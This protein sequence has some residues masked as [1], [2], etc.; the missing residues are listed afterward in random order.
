MVN[1]FFPIL[2]P[3]LFLFFLELFGCQILP[4]TIRIRVIWKEAHDEVLIAKSSHEAL[5][6]VKPM[7]AWCRMLW[8]PFIPPSR[9]ILCLKLRHDRLPT[10]DKLIV[11]GTCLTYVCRVLIVLRIQSIF[12]SNVLMGLFFGMLLVICSAWV[13][14]GV[15][16][17]LY[18]CLRLVVVVLVVHRF[19]PFRLRVLFLSFGLFRMLE[20][21]WF[22]R[23]L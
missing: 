5:C 11:R 20:T 6:E 10:E 2:F 15:W 19:V 13:F 8:K 14:L 22:L 9:A 12:F 16:V 3:L 23:I 1:G 21:W 17:H 18:P 4:N 7:L